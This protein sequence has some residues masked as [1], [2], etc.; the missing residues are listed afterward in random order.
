MSTTPASG[1]SGRKGKQPGIGARP[2][3]IRPLLLALPEREREILDRRANDETLRAVARDLGLSHQR[4][5]TLEE[6]AWSKLRA[7]ADPAS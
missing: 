5:A 7:G 2:P 6:R 3:Q 4:V 1:L